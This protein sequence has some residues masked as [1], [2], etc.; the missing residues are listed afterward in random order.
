MHGKIGN[1]AHAAT[2]PLHGPRAL[3]SR[4][5]SP[6]W[7]CCLERFLP[8]SWRLAND[9]GKSTCLGRLTS[10]SRWQE[11]RPPCSTSIAYV[12]INLARI[13]NHVIKTANVSLSPRWITCLN[14][15]PPAKPKPRSRACPRKRCA[16]IWSRRGSSS[17]RAIP[18]TQQPSTIWDQCKDAPAA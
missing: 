12:H 6:A 10:G 4:S 1:I 7:P 3:W 9:Q 18:F 8:F 16:S 11:T 15:P 2:H 13:W 14:W 5:R 17:A